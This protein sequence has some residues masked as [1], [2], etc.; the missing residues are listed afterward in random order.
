MW[1]IDQLR[2]SSVGDRASSVVNSLAPS[3][4]SSGSRNGLYHFNKEVE[5]YF[6][7]GV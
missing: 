6:M 4:S 7:E 3:R 1:G 2:S 5:I